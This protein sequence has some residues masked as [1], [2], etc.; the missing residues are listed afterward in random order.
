MSPLK[1]KIRELNT[2]LVKN[3]NSKY[4]YMDPK[5][6]YGMM[7]KSAVSGLNTSFGQPPGNLDQSMRIGGGSNVFSKLKGITKGLTQTTE[8]MTG[9]KT[10]MSLAPAIPGMAG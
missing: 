8:S 7:N 10:M 4:E 1:K 6:T 5:Y 2:T 9:V 3:M